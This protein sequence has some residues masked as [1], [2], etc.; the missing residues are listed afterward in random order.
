MKIFNSQQIHEIDMATCEAQ[1]IDSIEL[2]ER[3]A[4]AVT[5]EIISRFVP[6][7]RIVVI[8]GPGN[9]GG[10]AL[11][12]ARM[13][14]EQGYRKVEI[15][16][17]NIKGHLS[18]DCEEE[19]KRLIMIDGVDFNEITREFTP[20]A[21]GKDDVVIDGLFG[22]GLKEPLKGGFVALAR[23]I[24]ESGAYVVSIDM[25][26]GM[27]VESN[28]THNTRDMVHA[29]LTLSFQSPK[30]SFFFEE[31]A[32]VIGEWQLLDIDLDE[33]KMKEMPT[34]Y[35]LVESRNV[36]PKLTRRHPFTGKRDYGS[37]LLFA[38]NLGMMGAAVLAARAALRSGAGLAT[39]HSAA[40]GLGIVQT[41]VPEAM[42]EPDRDERFITDMTI[43]HN[44]QAIAAGPGIGTHEQ[45]IDALERMLKTARTP[46]ILDADAL[47]CIA[48]RPALLS[49]LPA[50]SIITPH[51][52]EFDR[53]F[54]ESK[55]SEERL[56]KA[57]SKAKY[58]NIIIVLKGHH[59]ATVRPTG[60]VY[61]NSTGNPGM[62]TAGAGDVLTGV[63][64]AFLAQ[65]YHPELAATIGVYIH[66]L[67]GDMAAEELGEY[68]MVA[69][70]I[71]D[72]VGRAIRAVI[73]HER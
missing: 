8:A 3:A 64:A 31:N 9:N 73:R 45:T 42:F 52:G 30:L 65:G 18:H 47:N 13:L 23:Y 21:L 36:R 28:D 50:K 35:I 46:L 33:A 54:G 16:L 58:Y 15:F 66:G 43:H 1:H 51:I 68:G 10:D 25:P 2:M 48:K 59:T 70:D 72:R 60:K 12:V 71:S 55:S 44:H 27:A 24:N 49:M 32:D 11:A 62:A 4:N 63:I 40:A 20:P 6:P 26:S 67:A 69:G 34:D 22:A 41:A 37:V 19:R 5:Y 56:R 17:F 61:F 57:I 7:K 14:I 38:G 29:N 53:L 39:V